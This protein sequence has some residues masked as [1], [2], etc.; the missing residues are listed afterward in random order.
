YASAYMHE[1]GHSLIGWPIPGH[2]TR[3]YYPW[4]I[5]FWIARPYKSCMNYGYMYT[6]VDYSDGSRPFGDYDDW[7]RMDLT[8]FQE[9]W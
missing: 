7:E 2:N 5:G 3:S 4:Q 6:S 8:S 1:T 9:D